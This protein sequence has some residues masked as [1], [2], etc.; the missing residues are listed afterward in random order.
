MEYRVAAA[1]MT[2]ATLDELALL[3]IGKSSRINAI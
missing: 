2:T 1:A 3:I